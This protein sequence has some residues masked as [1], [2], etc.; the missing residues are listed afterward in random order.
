MGM[1]AETPVV[2]LDVGTKKIAAVV[3]LRSRGGGLTYLDGTTVEARG[4]RNGIIVDLQDAVASIESALCDLEDRSGQRVTTVCVGVGGPHVMGVNAHAGVKVLPMGREI[5]HDDIASAITLAREA[6]PPMEN[7]DIIHEIPRAYRVDGQPGVTDPHGMLGYELEVDVHYSLGVSTT[8]ANLLKSVKQAQVLPEML[9]AAPLAAGEAIRE[10]YPHVANLAVVDIGAETTGLTIY[11]GGTLWSSEVFPGGG[12]DITRELASQLKI[13]LGAAE[14]VKL[15]YGAC[16][17]A[18]AADFELVDLPPSAGL[19]A[20]LPRAEV[21]RLIQQRA[22]TL[23]DVLCPRLE[24]ARQA[25]AEPELLALT[26]GGSRLLGLDKLLMPALEVPVEHVPAGARNVPGWLER[27]EFAVAAGLLLWHAHY[28]PYDLNQA[29][30]GKQRGLPKL[31]TQ[32]R[33]LV[34]SAMP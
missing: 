5:I 8:I 12:A 2:G 4:V 13:P 17:P 31:M 28:S 16:D 19:N 29:Q 34:G 23:A 6:L 18:A 22:Y 20:L 1:M 21:A 3:A 10:A 26:G 25:D 9:V 11:A 32:L 33:R 7:R 24:E 15:R 14:D 30:N 27:P